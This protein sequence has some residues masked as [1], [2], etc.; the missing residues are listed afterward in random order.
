MI[1]MWVMLARCASGH[2]SVGRGTTPALPGFA[3]PFHSA[4]G[5]ELDN[6][7]PR[8]ARPILAATAAREIERL[9]ARKRSGS[10]NM[11]S[12]PR[13]TPSRALPRGHATTKRERRYENMARREYDKAFAE[14]M[15]V[16]AEGE[17][18]FRESGIKSTPLRAW[19]VDSLIERIKGIQE[20]PGLR[21]EIQE[22]LGPI[23]RVD[24]GHPVAKP[25]DA[26]RGP[27]RFPRSSPPTSQHAAA[28]RG[29]RPRRR[30]PWRHPR[31]KR[32]RQSG[33]RGP[34]GFDRPA[35]YHRPA[36]GDPGG[37]RGEASAQPPGSQGAP[38]A[39]P[40]PAQAA[41]CRLVQTDGAGDDELRLDRV[42]SLLTIISAVKADFAQ[43]DSL[44]AE[45]P[46]PSLME[47]FAGPTRSSAPP[48]PVPLPVGARATA[49]LDARCRFPEQR[50]VSSPSPHRGEGA[51]RADEG[52]TSHRFPPS[53][54]SQK[55]LHQ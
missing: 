21:A 55:N 45:P 38:D 8:W 6:S 19:D 54:R 20:P 23:P 4:Q 15:R 37:G 3:R 46:A 53:E 36:A 24:E 25:P 7:R 44:R 32:Q 39:A 47:V 10:T 22:A 34:G 9:H 40:A 51:R 52:A 28:G 17:A 2:G 42:S 13:T 18:R 29:R 43:Y 12:T 27:A 35:F 33:Q 50:L 14:L 41:H 31:R 26:G 11:M 16:K 48:H 49:R 30:K 1:T 5:R